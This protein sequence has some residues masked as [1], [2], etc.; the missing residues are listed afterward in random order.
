M[1][2]SN[3]CKLHKGIKKKIKKRLNNNNINIYKIMYVCH[4]SDNS[5]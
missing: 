1:Y 4:N 2:E 3:D 5:L